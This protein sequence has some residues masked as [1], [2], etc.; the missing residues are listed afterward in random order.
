[1]RAVLCRERG[2]DA[3]VR[4]EEVPDPVPGEG[5]VRIGV[6]AAGVAFANLLVLAGTHQNRPALP[7]SPGTEVSGVVLSCGPGATRFAPGQR[8][9]AAVRHG[10]YAEQVV[11]PERTVFAVPDAVSH[12]AA[13]QFPTLYGT[14]YGALA[15]RARLQ[16]GETVLVHG[17]AGGSGLAALG[18]AKCLGARVIATASTE[19]KAQA[20]RRHGADVVVNHRAVSFREVVLAE[21][22]G[23]GADVVFDPVGGAVFDESLR[24]TAPDGRLLV[25]GFAG[26]QVPTVPANL[27]LVKNVDVIGLYWGQY[28]GW[29]RQA[30]LPGDEARVR[31][32]M[33]ELLGWCAQ[34]SLRPETRQ[35]FALE[36]FRDALAMIQAR[37]VIGRVA[38]C[39]RRE[40]EVRQWVNPA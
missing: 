5:E 25:I 13:V 7:F 3:A 12:E 18:V 20:C 29:G 26:G 9:M 1:M 34:G 15:W 10:G 8:V 40:D 35:V 24:C 2:N 22:G 23:R 33:A 17:A 38:L 37:E 21:T 36:A 14:A 4:V 28:L 11:A 31:A 27:V 32:A 6:C 30:S 19:D 39:P 16:P